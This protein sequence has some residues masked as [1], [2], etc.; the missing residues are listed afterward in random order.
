MV[1]LNQRE[2]IKLAVVSSNM[3]STNITCQNSLTFTKIK[4]FWPNKK[5]KISDLLAASG[6][7][8]TRSLRLP[9]SQEISLLN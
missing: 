1:L 6:V 3:A 2:N 7:F 9:S 5:Y 4:F 8:S